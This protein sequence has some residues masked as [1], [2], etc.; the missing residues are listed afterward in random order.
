MLS[1]IKIHASGNISEVTH[2]NKGD[3]KRFVEEVRAALTAA[4][5]N[6]APVAA[7]QEASPDPADQLR[8]LGELREAG[9][10]T[11]EEFAAKKQQ[12]LDRM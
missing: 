5:G 2:V 7:V 1:S 6:P 9:L 11:D 8:K 3:G 4:R 10:L 12:L